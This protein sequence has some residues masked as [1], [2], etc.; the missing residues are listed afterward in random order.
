MSPLN[1]SNLP[2]S[3]GRVILR[4]L[5]YMILQPLSCTASYIAIR[6]GKL[7]PH[8]LTLTFVK[9]GYFLLLNSA[10]TNS[11]PLDNRVLC[12]VRTFL[13]FCQKSDRSTDYTTKVLNFLK[14]WRIE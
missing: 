4:T 3:I 8:L 1:S 9:G 13:F 11:Y 6:T 2:P 5:V 10:L 12:V 7:L 14:S